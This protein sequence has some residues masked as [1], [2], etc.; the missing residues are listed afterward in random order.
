MELAGWGVGAG[1]EQGRT[2]APKALEFRQGPH[3]LENIAVSLTIHRWL[4]WARLHYTNARESS[5]QPEK[6]LPVSTCGCK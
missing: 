2:T 5:Q 6:K 3:S 1:G 4:P